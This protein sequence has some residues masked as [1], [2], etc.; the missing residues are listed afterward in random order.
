MAEPLRVELQLLVQLM[1]KQL[2]VELP[3]VVQLMG[4]QQFVEIDSNYCSLLLL[5][6]S[7]S[8]SAHQ[9]SHVVFRHCPYTDEHLCHYYY[10]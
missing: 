9:C 4:E 2:V 10:Y 6:S 7:S 8:L 1:M 5:L 3:M